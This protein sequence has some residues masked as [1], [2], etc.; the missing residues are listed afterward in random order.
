MIAR[1]VPWVCWLNP[2]IIWRWWWISDRRPLDRFW[3]WI[4]IC[5]DSFSCS[6]PAM[7]SLIK[8]LLLCVYVYMMECCASLWFRSY[9]VPLLIIPYTDA[10]GSRGIAQK[11]DTPT[12]RPP[13]STSSPERYSKEEVSSLQTF[14]ITF[15]HKSRLQPSKWCSPHVLLHF[16]YL[17]YHITHNACEY[18]CCEHSSCTNHQVP[19]VF[20]NIRWSIIIRL[21]S[22]K[23]EWQCEHITIELT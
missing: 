12:I 1:A 23:Y 15:K 20:L 13:S 6:S 10:S 7:I 8:T 2:R 4:A 18:W 19:R 11:R 3:D 17:K 16:I 5:V 14:H 21:M 9:N 22:K